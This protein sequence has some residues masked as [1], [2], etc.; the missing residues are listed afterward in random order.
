MG[1][2]AAIFCA[3]ALALPAAAQSSPAQRGLVERPGALPASTTPRLPASAT[4]RLPASTT[5]KLPAS[6]TLEQC[7]T[8]AS[9]DARSAT[10]A[11][12]MSAIPGTERMQMSVQVLE[13]PRAQDS[14]HLVSAPGLGV[15]RSSALGV[16]SYKYLRQVT[17]LDAPAYYR[18]A[19][20][21]R[22]LGAHGK[23]I[24]SLELRTRR[25][26]QTAPPVEAEAG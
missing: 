20:R 16:Q 10:F 4:P 21:F 13:R 8:A 25:C 12:E 15:W 3:A 19:I 6:A 26:L 14:Y 1:A 17:N 7:Q 5:P 2:A 11:G 9:E 23:T 22:W 18:A 24:A